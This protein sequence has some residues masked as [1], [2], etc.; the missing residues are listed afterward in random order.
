VDPT[1]SQRRAT[2]TAPSVKEFLAKIS[3][4]LPRNP[5]YSPDFASRDF[6]AMEN[7][8]KRQ[9]FETTDRIEKETMAHLRSL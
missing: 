1:A 7:R 8:S 2:H 5:A 9:H 3:I 4:L 6:F